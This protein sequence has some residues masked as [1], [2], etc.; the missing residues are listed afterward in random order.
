[1]VDIHFLTY[2]LVLLVIICGR[3]NYF[4]II[5]FIIIFHD[6]GHILVMLFFNIKI[7]KLIILPF[8]SIIDSDIKYNEK[9]YIKLLISVAGVVN[10]LL[11]FI[12]FYYLLRYNIISYISYSI[13]LKYNIYII[14]FNLL[15]IYPLDGLKIVS[16]LLECIIP[17]KVHLYVINTISLLSLIVLIGITNFSFD[18]FN[19]LFFLFYKTYEEFLNIKY[20]F[21]KFLLERY[22]YG[23]SYRSI[24]YVSSINYIYKNKYNFINNVSENKIIN[25]L[26]K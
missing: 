12:L 19:V 22:L 6:L 18:L 1:M 7:N 4:I 9:S 10:Q 21:Y 3:F 15:P 17:Y 24:R 25:K 20:I 5:S 8:G 26:F 13:F 11:L 14:V 16:S 2:I 23:Y